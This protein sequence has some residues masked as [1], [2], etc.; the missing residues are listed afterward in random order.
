[1][2]DE[3]TA[4]PDAAEAPPPAPAPAAEQD[5]VEHEVD[6][7][8]HDVEYWK[9]EAEE[10]RKRSE[11]NHAKVKKLGAVEKQLD[12]LR[13]A[14]RSEVERAVESARRDERERWQTKYRTQA[15]H[16]AVLRV[17]GAKLADPADALRLLELDPADVVDDDGHTDDHAVRAAVDDL[18]A[19]KPYLS[20]TT[21][22][23]PPSGDQGARPRPA[24]R[25]LDSLSMDDYMHE[26]RPGQWHGAG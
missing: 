21:R 22:R 24:A 18:L 11:G 23:L 6:D 10:W 15:L 25:S 3:Q 7:A 16:N 12:E 2:S 13:D 26:T 1:M 19:R 14:G 5:T 8:E 20:S 4:A 17:A 9:R